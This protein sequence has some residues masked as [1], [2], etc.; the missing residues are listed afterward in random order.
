MQAIEIRLSE[1]I[2]AFLYELCLTQSKT[3]SEAHRMKILLCLLSLVLLCS[4]VPYGST[5]YRYFSPIRA[6]IGL[7]NSL[8]K[9]RASILE[10][11]PRGTPRSMVEQRIR[12]N[13]HTPIVPVK[14]TALRYP[15]AH[16]DWS[17]F[18]IHLYTRGLFPGG[19]DEAEATFIFDKEGRLQDVITF[20][21][22][23]W[24]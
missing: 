7:S 6:K 5:T 14:L 3:H 17:G 15:E 20:D 4:C 8:S 19:H 13:F 23:V 24:L 18:E 11:F 12:E 16:L 9:I 10:V 21:D 1:E 2:F 22:G